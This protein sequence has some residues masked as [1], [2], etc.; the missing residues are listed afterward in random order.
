MH[1]AVSD[2][3]AAVRNVIEHPQCSK[4]WDLN[5]YVLRTGDMQWLQFNICMYVCASTLAG[6]CSSYLVYVNISYVMYVELGGRTLFVS[7]MLSSKWFAQNFV[8]F[9]TFFMWK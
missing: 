7:K 9:N 2:A 1:G 8:D 4:Q 6:M 5:M 3:A